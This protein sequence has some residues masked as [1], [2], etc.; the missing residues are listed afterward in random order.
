MVD[1]HFFDMLSIHNPRLLL[2]VFLGF[3]NLSPF[4]TAHN[5]QKGTLCWGEN[6]LVFKELY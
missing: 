5:V 2:I 1:L 3:R 6:P 4:T